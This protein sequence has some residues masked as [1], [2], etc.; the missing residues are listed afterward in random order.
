MRAATKPIPDQELLSACVD[1]EAPT[2]SLVWRVRSPDTFTS[3]KATLKSVDNWNRA[4]A[5]KPAFNNRVPLTG[6]L[7]GCLN[8]QEIYA[9]RLI[10][11]LVHDAEPPCIDHV[12]GDKADNR[13][14]NLRAADHAINAQ[15]RKLLTPGKPNGVFLLKNG[16]WRAH[17]KYRGVVVLQRQCSSFDEAVH[18]RRE[19]EQRLGLA[20]RVEA[21]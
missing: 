6:Y 15:N 13:L 14:C 17:L 1:Y 18:L 20:T 11:K 21:V 2:G 7:R 9:H 19:M 5:G 4:H 16:K 12:N 8:Y 10:W 3:A